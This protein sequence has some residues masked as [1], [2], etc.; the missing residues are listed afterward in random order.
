MVNL[1]PMEP[2][3]SRPPHGVRYCNAKTRNGGPCKHEAG[4]GTDHPGFG[5]CKFHFGATPSGRKAAARQEAALRVAEW[6]GRLDVT[7]PEALLELVRTKAAE[8]AYWN[9]RVADVEG[10]DEPPEFYL[11]MLHRAQDQLGTYAAAAIKTGLEEALVTVATLQGRLI[12]ELGRRL[13][14]ARDADPQ[15]KPDD[16]IRGVLEGWEQ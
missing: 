8:V 7:P 6:G 13:L 14:D 4:W 16:L 11:T 1:T 3:R 9:G 10:T 5:T 15:A 12:L 2:A